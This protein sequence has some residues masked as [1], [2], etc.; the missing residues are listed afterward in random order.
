M[1][2]TA[3]ESYEDLVSDRQ[4]LLALLNSLT[5]PV[6]A[7]DNGGKIYLYNTAAQELVG[8][9]DDLMGKLFS[10]VL[11]LTDSGGKT[12]DLFS[13]AKDLTDPVER[14]DLIY[15]HKDT[16]DV[17]L[18]VTFTPV[19]ASEADHKRWGGYMIACR[20]I[21]HERESE[22]EKE[23]F[24]AVTSHELRTPLAI[25]EANLSTVL[26]P[27]VAKMSDTA[28]GMVKQAHDNVLHL[29]DLVKDLTT[30][31][32]AEN[33]L[34]Q[35]S[36]VKVDLEELVEEM[37]RDYAAHA[38][39]KGLEL[40]R[41]VKGEARVVLTNCSELREIMQNLIVNAIKYTEKGSVVIETEYLPNG[42]RVV[43]RDTGIGI[44]PAD[45][46]KI[47]VKFFRSEDARVRLASGTG[48][49][50]YISRKL[51]DH[52]GLDLD[53][54]SVPEQ[55]STFSVTIPYQKIP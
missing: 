53:F 37:R 6:F 47:F 11:P 5:S 8:A 16:P 18:D 17:F 29:I 50:L 32:R 23:E 10:S 55:G 1:K 12:V 22:Q 14:A 54:V 46:K 39:Q 40:S 34:S 21:T 31:S 35:E 33:G 25:A 52:L 41:A 28:S 7:L 19:H 20:D 4:K 3:A 26:V 38:K 2:P 51:A 13:L 24:I 44:A 15:C 45:Q 27:G 43:V 49:G 48:L 9:K 42:A 30:L 36:L